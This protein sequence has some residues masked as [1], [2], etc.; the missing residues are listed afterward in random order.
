[1]YKRVGNHVYIYHKFL[2]FLC[3]VAQSLTKIT[4]L[5]ANKEWTR[6]CNWVTSNHTWRLSKPNCTETSQLRNICHPHLWYFFGGTFSS[7]WLASDSSDSLKSGNISDVLWQQKKHRDIIPPQVPHVAS[8]P[9]ATLQ[10]ARMVRALEASSRPL[11]KTENREKEGYLQITNI[12]E[13]E[14]LVSSPTNPPQLERNENDLNHPHPWGHVPAVNLLVNPFKGSQ[15]AFPISFHRCQTA[16]FVEP[17]FLWTCDM[18][19]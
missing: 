18:N 9:C 7:Q 5:V 16:D 3:G 6:N 8:W 17:N 12:L 1:M 14:R 10:H 19:F 2:K 4:P 13:D 15:W 11:L